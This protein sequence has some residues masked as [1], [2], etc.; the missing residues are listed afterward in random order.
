MRIAVSLAI[1]SVVSLALASAQTTNPAAPRTLQLATLPAG[2]TTLTGCLKGHPDGYYLMEKD[3]TMR[4]LMSPSDKLK[5]YSTKRAQTGS[6]VEARVRPSETDL[7]LF[8][9]DGAVSGDA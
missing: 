7:S 1:F 2:E 9:S 4:L 5:P 8:Y 6:S 3:G